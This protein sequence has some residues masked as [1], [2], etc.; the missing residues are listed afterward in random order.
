MRPVAI[1]RRLTPA[2]ASVITR[3]NTES[4]TFIGCPSCIPAAL[5]VARASRVRWLIRRRSN[6]ENTIIMPA[7]AS[8]AGVLVSAARSQ[9][10]SCQPSLRARSSRVPASAIERLTRS[11]LDAMRAADLRA[12]SVARAARRAGR[13]DGIRPPES[14]SSVCH[15]V[16]VQPRRS[17][18]AV[19]AARWASRPCSSRSR[20]PSA[21]ARSSSTT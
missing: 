19:I 16:M 4:D 13:L 12:L 8:P 9:V 21:A 10:T 7:A 18:S 15:S 11:S 17:A 5:R 20:L 6:W 3:R 2:A 1:L 14:A